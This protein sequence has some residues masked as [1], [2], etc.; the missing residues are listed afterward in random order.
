MRYII[1][2]TTSNQKLLLKLYKKSEKH[3]VR[4]RAHCILLSFKGFS[5]GHL[6]EIF[7]V[8]LNTIYNWFNNWEKNGIASLNRCTGQGCKLK[9]GDIKPDII[10]KLVEK[11]PN[12]LKKV[13]LEL[14]RK[15]GTKVSVRTL[16]RFIKKN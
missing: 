4:Q 5:I 8:H 14:D 6:I 13:V 1:N 12:R 3:E 11:Y 7:G 9:L 2:L 16:I 10:R 15:H